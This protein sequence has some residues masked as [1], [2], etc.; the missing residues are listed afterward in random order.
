MNDTFGHEAVDELLQ[1]FANRL[2]HGLSANGVLAR[3]GDD[4]F[5]VVMDGM[6]DISAVVEPVDRFGFEVCRP[7]EIAGVNMTASSSAGIVDARP[8]EADGSTMLCRAHM[9]MYHAK[10][11]HRSSVVANADLERISIRRTDLINE[12]SRE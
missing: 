6:E 1:V 9:A 5:A 12:L 7:V 3:L 4:E 10:R 11:L 8:G 2:D